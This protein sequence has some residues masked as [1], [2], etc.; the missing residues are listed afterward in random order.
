MS[1]FLSKSLVFVTDDNG[2]IAPFNLSSQ[3]A[4]DIP[5]DVDNVYLKH[6]A[7]YV[8][9]EDGNL[10][11]AKQTDFGGSGGSI[12]NTARSTANQAATDIRLSKTGT[13]S[14]YADNPNVLAVGDVIE[15]KGFFDSSD[16]NVANYVVK[17]IN[18]LEVW[19]TA[20]ADGIIFSDKG[21]I[22]CG[23]SK[24]LE[25]KPSNKVNI[26][27]FG[28][29]K[30]GTVDDYLYLKAALDFCKYRF[31]GT[32]TGTSLYIPQGFYRTSAVLYVDMTKLT[33]EGDGI[34]SILLP[35]TG[36]TGDCFQIKRGNSTSLTIKNMRF[37]NFQNA[38]TPF[39][40][41]IVVDCWIHHCW[42]SGNKSA[43]SGDFVTLNCTNNIFELTTDDCIKSTGKFRKVEINSNHF[44]YNSKRCINLVGN[45]TS[46]S[47]TQTTFGTESH[48]ITIAGNMFDQTNATVTPTAFVYLENVRHAIL[49]GNQ[50]N[51]MT[52]PTGLTVANGVEL[53]NC[54]NIKIADN[55]SFLSGD[56][57]KMTGCQVV[58]VLCNMRSVGR[59]VNATTSDFVNV[60]GTIR[61]VTV[62]SAVTFNTV[63]K[64]QVTA[65]ISDVTV[66]AGV[67]ASS[68]NDIIIRALVNATSGDGIKVLSSTDF[69]VD[70]EAIGS[71]G[72]H[73]V[74]IDTCNDF[75]IRGLY[76]GNAQCGVYLKGSNRGSVANVIARGNNSA[77]NASYAGIIVGGTTACAQIRV[78]ECNMYGNGTYNLRMTSLASNCRVENNYTNTDALSTLADQGTGNTLAN[79]Y[80]Y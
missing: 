64:S 17:A 24:K 33:I 9:G 77:A 62:G 22:K 41:N 45:T 73:G 3:P 74:D 42:F 39:A 78:K 60:G 52:P 47:T 46:G 79:N 21:E 35:F 54:S 34:G 65:V 44:Y 37:D 67:N 51:G 50:Y 80:S 10:R 28:A 19:G 32:S 49:S 13:V 1:V 63:T 23:T 15:A 31:D 61:Y 8:I 12:D 43:I 11:P 66:G 72:G 55:I 71:T 30:G 29:G 4:F 5:N 48:A 69:T 56:G 58:D 25:Y 76:R 27:H 2:N 68:C 7:L 14:Y 38:I 59:G 18:G 16:M 57:V 36:Y 75:I 26:R 53:L 6:E 20:T 70:S 40:G